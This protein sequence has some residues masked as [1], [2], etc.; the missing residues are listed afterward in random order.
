M[1]LYILETLRI[2]PPGPGLLRVCTKKFKIPDSDITLDTG[3]KILIPT[4]SLHHDPV[5]YPNPELFDPLRFTEDNKATRPNGTFL[6]F[7]DGPRI[8][9]GKYII[10]YIYKFLFT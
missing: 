7:G 2:H 6:P 9:I 10:L 8:C 3:M 1:L 4:Y 5:Y